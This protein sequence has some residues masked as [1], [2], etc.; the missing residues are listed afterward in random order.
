[1]YA[2]SAMTN[3]SDRRTHSI[4]GIALICLVAVASMATACTSMQTVMPPKTAPEA[5]LQIHAHE[6]VRVY[7]RD[8]A[9]HMLRVTDLTAAALVGTTAAALPAG[10]ARGAQLTLEIPYDEITRL[11]VR[12]TS[13][14]KTTV[15]VVAGVLLVVGTV[16]AVNTAGH[17]AGLNAL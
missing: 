1:M 11:D 4:R 8:G 17:L 7:T 6:I 15:L 3:L 2:D 10:A 14:V 5:R 12:R 9:N 13:V 16:A